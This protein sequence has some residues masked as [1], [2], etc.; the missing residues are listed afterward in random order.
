MPHTYRY[1]LQPIWILWLAV[2]RRN[3]ETE[4][5]MSSTDAHWN[6]GGD[7]DMTWNPPGDKIEF[8]TGDFGGGKEFGGGN[9][10]CR[11]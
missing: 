10:A 7:N 4:C 2:C 8:D 3:V 5:S 6:D 1:D 11:K 9:D